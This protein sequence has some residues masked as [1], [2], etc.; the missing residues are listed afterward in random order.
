[1]I[2]FTRLSNNL[3]GRRQQFQEMIQAIAIE[4]DGAQPVEGSGGD[5][6]LDAFVGR[7]GGDIVSYEAKYFEGRLTSNRKGQV[8]RSL[9]T[10]KRNHPDLR[11]WILATSITLTTPELQWWQ[12]LVDANP[13]IEMVLWQERHIDNHLNNPKCAGIREAYLPNSSDEIRRSSTKSSQE[14][15]QL[16]ETIEG[17]SQQ[18]YGSLQGLQNGQTN[19]SQRQIDLQHFIEERLPASEGSLA[20]QRTQELQRRLEEAKRILDGH[21]PKTALSL[22]RSILEDSETEPNTIKSKANNGIAACHLHQEDYQQAEVFFRK[23]LECTPE[24]PKILTNMAFIKFLQDQNEE[25]RPFIEKAYELDP[26]N[27]HVV[28]VFSRLY[29]DE[30]KFEEAKSLFT[31]E[32]LKDPGCMLTYGQIHEHCGEIGQAKEWYLK[33]VEANPN[34]PEILMA[35][36]ASLFMPI[37]N[38]LQAGAIRPIELTQEQR[39]QLVEGEKYLILASE[40]LRDSEEPNKY[41]LALTNRSG[42]RL[43]LLDAETALS[44]AEDALEISETEHLCWTNKGMS[45]LHLHRFDEAEAAYRKALEYGSDQIPTIQKIAES[46]ILQ[47]H[48]QDAV[49]AIR[50]LI[51]EGEE[52]NIDASTLPLALTLAEAFLESKNLAEAR[53]LLNTLHTLY[54]NNSLILI[55]FGDLAKEDGNLETTEDFYNQAVNYSND[56][57][58]S[59]AIFKLA[60]FY[61]HTRDF[62][63]AER[64]LREIINVEI[65]NLYLKQYLDCLMNQEKYGECVVITSKLREQE[66][67]DP[68]L[69]H[70]EAVSQENLGQLKNALPL[71]QQ[72]IAINPDESRYYIR[73]GVCYY[74]LGEIEDS[75]TSFRTAL[76]LGVQDPRDRMMIA[77]T[78]SSLGHSWDAITLAYDALQDAIDDFQMHYA[79]MWLFLQ[80][81]PEVGNRIDTDAVEIDTTVTF[82]RDDNEPQTFLI[83]PDTHG[84]VARDEIKASSPLAQHLLGHSKGDTFEITDQASNDIT[85]SIHEIKSKYVVAFQSAFKDFNTRFL[86]Q[87]GLEEIRV[88]G[89]DFSELFRRIDRA[90]DYTEQVV[91]SYRTQQLPISCFAHMLNRDLFTIWEGLTLQPDVKMRSAYGNEEEKQGEYELALSSDEIVIDLIAMFT[92]KLLDILDVFPQ[93]FGTIYVHQHSLDEL[94]QIIETNTPV[95]E[96]RNRTIGRDGDQ[97]VAQDETEEFT[98]NKL[99]F[100]NDIRDFILTHATPCGLSTEQ[101]VFPDELTDFM[102]YSSVNSIALA[103]EKNV[104][105]YSDDRVFRRLAKEYEVVGFWTQNML[106]AAVEKGIVEKDRYREL[107]QILLENNYDFI[108]INNSDIVYALKAS[109]FDVS[110]RR[111]TKVLAALKPASV[112]GVQAIAI[113]SDVAKEIWFEPIPLSTK[114][115]VLFSMLETLTAERDRVQVGQ[116]FIQ[117]VN[118]KF[119]LIQYQRDE[120]V[121]LVQAWLQEHLFIN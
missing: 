86:G 56:H 47:E 117:A 58:K 92:L 85:I 8:E 104:P 11:R 20:A 50:T 67:G 12:E 27:A 114:R 121:R 43:A 19:L 48:G 103:R 60:Q 101:H 1:M 22:Y 29:I 17:N 70:I 93:I 72:L 120:V 112:I 84:H 108:A 80:R 66:L 118:I 30:G 77:Q 15:Q 61:L 4:I 74:R 73:Q 94:N 76:S 95:G 46:C 68:G 96:G 105:L 23:A 39:N 91:E 79:Y 36:A 6:G 40:K 54:P 57:D 42:I 102:G 9:G 110:H 44:L 18:V 25:G 53:I 88:E 115:D 16:A 69:L 2:D 75:E 89:E 64:A 100:L 45:L 99:H 32:I 49:D 24:D 119:R 33:A 41:I 34:D 106:R 83:V 62:E 116:T 31:E 37:I 28:N 35:Y 78:F 38:R 13:G 26:S 90:A 5:T 55:R 10:A 97:Y 52:E 81:S 87:G 21:K 59:Y 14:H 109:N 7:I 65:N 63:K 71:Y 98:Q 111:F 107:I 82:Q 113:C 3:P 51:P